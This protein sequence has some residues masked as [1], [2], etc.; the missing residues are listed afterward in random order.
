MKILTAVVIGVGLCL[1]AKAET[2]SPVGG[3]A[4]GFAGSG[5]IYAVPIPGGAGGYSITGID[6]PGVTGLIG[7]NGFTGYSDG[8][9][10]YSNDNQ[11]LPNSS[12]ALTKGGFAFTDTM[13]YVN[14]KVDLFAHPDG[15]YGLNV[16][17]S[18]GF[19]LNDTPATFELG[20]PTT[21]TA[22]H[23]FLMTQRNAFSSRTV[24]FTFSFAQAPATTPEPSSIVLLGTGLMG[25]AGVLRRRL[26]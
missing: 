25:M 4:Y 10:T 19:S 17:G 14:L 11:L 3:S 2:V 8:T 13:D 1:G 22:M 15:T 6:G 21:V 16:L 7:S 24:A 9:V 5:T 23:S 20:S 26:L 12:P 18:D